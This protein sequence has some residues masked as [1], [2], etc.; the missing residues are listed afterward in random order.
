MMREM[1]MY[2]MRTVKTVSDGLK[3]PTAHS[4]LDGNGATFE[5]DCGLAVLA[6][7]VLQLTLCTPSSRRARN[8]R[9]RALRVI[10]DKLF[11]FLP[12]PYCPS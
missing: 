2:I 11:S 5:M 3:R 8:F 9:N 4:S 6:P 7:A 10:T 12:L 1:D